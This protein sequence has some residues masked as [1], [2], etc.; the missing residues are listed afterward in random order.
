MGVDFYA[1]DW[2]GETFPDC[3]DY[4]SCDCGRMWCSDECAEN[5]GYREEQAGR[6][7]YKRSCKFCRK[8]DVVDEKLLNHCLQ[9][10]GIS[11][12]EAVANYFGR[13]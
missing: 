3:G 5:E 8:E 10:L 6:C 7:D 9:R 13:G 11:R 12:E 1:C 2:C 4:V